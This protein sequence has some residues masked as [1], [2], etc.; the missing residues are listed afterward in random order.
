MNAMRPSTTREIR[1]LAAPDVHLPEN[2]ALDRNDRGSPTRQMLR[3]ESRG[4]DEPDR[5]DQFEDAE[6]HPNLPRQRAKER[7]PR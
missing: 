5:A 2:E 1:D 7:D 4:E 6:G 3:M